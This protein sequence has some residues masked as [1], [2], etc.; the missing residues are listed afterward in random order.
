M[1][2]LRLA[3]QPLRDFADFHGRSTR[4]ELI[5]FHFASQFICVVANYLRGRQRGGRHGRV[6]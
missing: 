5:A 3:L 1:N 4:T 6:S 2:A